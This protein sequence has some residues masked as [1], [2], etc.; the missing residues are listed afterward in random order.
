MAAPVN[1]GAAPVNYGAAPVNNGAAPVNYGAA[2]VNYAYQETRQSKC[3][4]YDIS[5][6]RMTP[7]FQYSLAVVRSVIIS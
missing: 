1:Y 7:F 3:P 2:P 4:L 5:I 6:S